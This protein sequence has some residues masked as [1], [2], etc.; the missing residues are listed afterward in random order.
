MAE[1]PQLDYAYAMDAITQEKHWTGHHRMGS[2]WRPVAGGRIPNL[3]EI[4]MALEIDGLVRKGWRV[5]VSYQRSPRG[6]HPDNF[7][8]SLLIDNARV[9]AF[10]SG[11]PTKHRNKV[12]AGDR[13]YQQRVDHP[14][15]HRPVEE[16]SEGY[17]EPLDPELT[18]SALWQL[19]LERARI[20]GAPD[21]QPPPWEQGELL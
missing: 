10:D 7:S 5:I 3:F 2:L 4:H 16:A 1:K 20:N 18:Q 11:K 19:F 17:A 12:G 21:F 8:A 6:F 13:Y 15:W 9:L 14:H